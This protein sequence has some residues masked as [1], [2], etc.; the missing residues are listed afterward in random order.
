[1]QLIDAFLDFEPMGAVVRIP[2]IVSKVGVVQNLSND[3]VRVTIG[4]G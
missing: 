2:L 3:V 4:I 1:M